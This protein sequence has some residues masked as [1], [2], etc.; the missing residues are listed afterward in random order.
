[1]KYFH[2]NN[3]KGKICMANMI[4][5]KRLILKTSMREN[6]QHVFSFLSDPDVIRYIGNGPKTEKEVHDG[7]EKMLKHQERYGFGFGDI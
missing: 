7:I 3:V 2:V 1:M 4:E 6:F 5:T